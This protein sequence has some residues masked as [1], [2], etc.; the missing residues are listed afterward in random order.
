MAATSFSDI[1][2]QYYKRSFLFVKSYV[3]DDMAAEDITSES[4]IN[5]W[6]AM[7]E[8]IVNNPQNLLLTILKNNALNYL[9][10][11]TVRQ[12]VMESISSKMSRDLNYRIS[13]L[14]ACEP[15]DIFSSEITR[16]VETTLLS[17]PEQTR[18]IFEMSRYESMPVKG[19]AKKLSISEKSVEYHITKSLKVLRI[20][21]KDYLPV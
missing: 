11:Q 17:L 18:H 8:E 21:L 10:H 5:L 14:E 2:T 16:I 9:K 1:Y 13:T 6:H 19:I 4:L 7:N 15:E 3:H 12:K 20:A